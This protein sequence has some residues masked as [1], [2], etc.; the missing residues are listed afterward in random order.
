MASE[1]TSRIPTTKT[2]IVASAIIP[3][4]IRNN[5]DK[6][7]SDKAGFIPLYSIRAAC[8][9]FEDGDIPEVEGWVD[10]SGYG[11]RLDPEKHFVVH[12]KGDS[13]LPKI[14]DGD[15]CV[16]E[17]Y[18]AGSRNGE[19]VLTQCCDYDSEYGGKYTIKKYNSE[20]AVTDEGW[21]HTK[22]ELMPLN[23]DY[24]VIEL[25]DSFEYKTIGILKTI[26]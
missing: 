4:V 10:V 13:M 12:A 19:I 15:L 14:H 6:R 26:L 22:V 2:K 25:D 16:F 7:R 1:S 3:H 23:K 24:E 21:Q 20:K 5:A 18:R 9:Y 17:W 11:F 8:G